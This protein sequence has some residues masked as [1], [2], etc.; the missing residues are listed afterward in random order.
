MTA[1]DG[2]NGTAPGH[3]C[4]QVTRSLTVGGQEFRLHLEHLDDTTV[5]VDLLVGHSDQPA[6]HLRG[7]L[8]ASDV[9]PASQVLASLFGGVA[10]V[11]G[12]AGVPAPARIAQIRRTHPNAYAPWTS[13]DEAKLIERYH[14]GASI[15]ELAGEFGRKAGAIGRRLERLLPSEL[16]RDSDQLRP[17]TF[18]T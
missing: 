9:V 1:M 14:E 2:F 17:L 18:R 7:E 6:G 3:D 5:T 4:I 13:A 11:Q 15:A 10:V 8:Q 12:H 16:R